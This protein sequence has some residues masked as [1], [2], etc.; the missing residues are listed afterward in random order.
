MSCPQTSRVRPRSCA[1]P[2][3]AWTSC[4]CSPV[5]SS[6]TASPTTPATT[7]AR[8]CWRRTASGRP[9]ARPA[10]SARPILP[11]NLRQAA[12]GEG[13]AGVRPPAARPQPGPLRSEAGGG[14]GDREGRAGRPDAVRRRPRPRG[15]AVTQRSADSPQEV[16][17][18]PML[19][20]DARRRE[21]ACSQVRPCARHQSAMINNHR[22][23]AWSFPF[24]M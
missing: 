4:R 7:R 2:R 8:R 22:N 11:R 24:E 20:N 23:P 21:I 18:R 16:R 10:R 17:P 15:R 6:G 1:R 5:P 9:T 13:S 14:R 3:S 12:G 19:A